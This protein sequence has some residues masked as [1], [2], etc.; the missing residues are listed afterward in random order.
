L[1]GD[2]CNREG[3]KRGRPST[4]DQEELLNNKPHFMYANEKSNTKDCAVCSNRE[5]KGG[6]TETVFYCKTCS[7]KPGLHPEECFEKYHTLKKY[8]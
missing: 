4:S 3:K 7:R 6:R 5:V 1:V 2:I 8:K